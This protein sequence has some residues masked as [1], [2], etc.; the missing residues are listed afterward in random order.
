MDRRL[1]LRLALATMLAFAFACAAPRR[2]PAKRYPI[3]GQVLALNADKHEITIKHGDIPGFMPAMI[4]TYGAEPRAMTGRS[5]G[6]LIRGTL[7]VNDS[8]ATLVDITHVGSAPLPADSNSAA[9]AAGVLDVGDAVPDGAFIDQANHR[10]SIS[11]WKGTPLVVS[12]V[13]LSCPLPD[14]CPLMEQNFATLQRRLRDDTI[15]RGRV[16]LVTFTFDPARDT[17][18]ALAARAAALKTD[19]DLWTWLTGDPVTVEKF[20]AQFGISIIRTPETPADLT[21]NLRTFLVGGDGRIVKI[22]SGADW[23]PGTV[24]TDLR[25]L[26][27]APR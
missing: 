13:Y 10:R 20:A 17:P 9:L 21:H 16:H 4:M 7:E 2:E 12:F 22:Y 8:L 23:T 6:E 19:P 11:D 1:T 5:A 14:F 18:A 25:A 15:L 3:E 26:V 24:L 27:A